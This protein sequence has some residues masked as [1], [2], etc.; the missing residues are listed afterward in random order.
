MEPNETQI[1]QVDIIE[2]LKNSF[3]GEEY[4]FFNTSF[5]ENIEFNID[6]LSK[7]LIQPINSLVFKKCSS[8]YKIII[9]SLTPIEIIFNECN[10][11]SIIEVSV[12]SQALK[13]KSNNS[14]AILDS[15]IEELNVINSNDF[16]FICSDSTFNKLSLVN[17]DN[18]SKEIYL[19]NSKINYEINISNLNSKS[20]LGLYNCNL[21][22]NTYI[23]NSIF[24][25]IKI[26]NTTSKYAFNINE[27]IS[28]II[29][30]DF[31]GSK[32]N[33][34]SLQAQEINL[35][36][37]TFDSNFL[38]SDKDIDVVE[39]DI[40]IN[41]VKIHFCSFNE[42]AHIFSNDDNPNTF[43]IKELS[44]YS[45]SLSK[46]D[47]AF[48][49]LELG[50]VTFLGNI[51]NSN[52][53]LNYCSITSFILFK[54]LINKGQI[55][56]TSVEF[57]D[58]A[59]ISF[60]HAIMGNFILLNTDL[61]KCLWLIFQK[62]DLGQVN[63]VASKW[64]KKIIPF[65]D[66]KKHIPV[67]SKSLIFN[68]QEYLINYREYYRQLKGAC[69]RMQDRIQALEFQSL[70]MKVYSKQL[71][72]TK[73]ISNIDRI[74][75]ILGKTN[76]Y[77]QNWFRPVWLVLLITAIMHVAITVG[78]DP[79]L[80]L[81]EGE[82]DITFL[83]KKLFQHFDLFTQLLNPLHALERV[84]SIKIEVIPPAVW[85]LDYIHRLIVAFFI[86]QTV[87][88]FRKYVKS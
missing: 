31:K 62:S 81:T 10:Y 63:F 30:I 36:Y 70:E 66:Y 52:S 54:N 55:A 44:L 67:Y 20:S 33:I 78:V 43:R 57:S 14:I 19:Y 68:E 45:S 3:A 37:C 11:D 22:C 41:S 77:G 65:N 80:S 42:S 38:I 2:A 7:E 73:S 84:P 40:E 17:C 28:N 72:L 8:S 56:L 61:E 49:N 58:T 83:G 71:A 15:N 69:E 23:N 13:E 24:D 27:C 53:T 6:I 74:I 5:S 85:L 48:T 4:V 12:N 34:N 87:T 26:S 60:T 86:F 79:E 35:Y 59:I 88:A 75:L 9:Q 32:V 82:F 25:R 21:N 76:E 50:Q 39:K 51:Q 1:N 16:K 29:W 64:P 46:G 18:L 47:F